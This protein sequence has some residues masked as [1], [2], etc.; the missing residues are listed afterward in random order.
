MVAARECEQPRA[1]RRRDGRRER[2]IRFASVPEFVAHPLEAEPLHISPSE[3]SLVWMEAADAPEG[4]HRVPR[5][6]E[7]APSLSRSPAV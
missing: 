6:V 7:H 5:G 4:G 1:A 2:A 3:F